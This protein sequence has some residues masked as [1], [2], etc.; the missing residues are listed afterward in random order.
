MRNR[1]KYGVPA[2]AGLGVA[3]VVASQGGDPME[4]IGAGAAGTLGGAAG[5]LAARQ[6]AGKYSPEMIMQLQRG[7]TGAG[8]AVG[9]YARNLPDDSRVRRGLADTAADVISAVDNRVLGLPGQIDVATQN[10]QRNIGKATAAGL[11]PVAAG[12]AALGGMAAGQGV[13]AIGQA[14]GI[15]PEAPGSSNTLGS[16]LNMQSPMYM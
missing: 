14:L 9:D 3:G 6:L 4:V 13:G 10:L 1:L 2:A 8:N 15:D 5:L 12:T 11:V 7:V 16:R